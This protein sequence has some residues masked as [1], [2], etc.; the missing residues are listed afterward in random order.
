VADTAVSSPY[1]SAARA[2]AAA[3]SRRPTKN[4]P[5]EG[6]ALRARHGQDGSPTILNFHAYRR[7]SLRSGCEG[8]WSTRTR[9]GISCS[10]TRG[11]VILLQSAPPTVYVVRASILAAA[12]RPASTPSASR[13]TALNYY[14]TSARLGARRDDQGAGLRRRRSRLVTTSCGSSSP[15][16]LAEY[17]AFAGV[18]RGHRGAHRQ[19]PAYRGHSDF[20]GGRPQHQA[21]PWREFARSICFSFF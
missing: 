2:A 9:R 12:P 18:R 1:A 5:D 20:V 8:S 21:R 19:D 6:S 13:R 4:A 17:L 7:S 11:L 16:H 10:F 15:L 3:S 14:G